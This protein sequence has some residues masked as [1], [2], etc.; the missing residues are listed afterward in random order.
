MIIIGDTFKSIIYLEFPTYVFVYLCI[1]QPNGC[2]MWSPWKRPSL[3]SQRQESPPEKKSKI[4]GNNPLLI[5][6]ESYKVIFKLCIGHISEHSTDS[7]PTARNYFWNMKKGHDRPP[8]YSKGYW[9][10]RICLDLRNHSVWAFAV[11]YTFWPNSPQ[12]VGRIW[13]KCTS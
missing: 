7:L 4:N 3:S 11:R 5:W 8:P 12:K 10:F 6:F 1:I 2:H 9:M 13:Q